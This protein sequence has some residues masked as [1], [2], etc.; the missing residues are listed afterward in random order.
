MHRFF[1]G[2]GRS[3]EQSSGGAD[4]PVDALAGRLS[5]VS[6]FDSLLSLTEQCGR[7]IQEAM[8]RLQGA[9]QPLVERLKRFQ[10]EVP[11]SCEPLAQLQRQLGACGKQLGGGGSSL[12]A[13]ARLSSEARERSGEVHR[14]FESRGK[15]LAKKQQCSQEV[16][17]IHKRFGPAFS[18]ESKASRLKAKHEAEEEFRVRDEEAVQKVA[19][20]LDHRWAFLQPILAELC[21]WHA[22]VFAGAEELTVGLAELATRLSSPPAAGA[23]PTLEPTVSTSTAPA[24]GCG[25]GDGGT[26]APTPLAVCEPEA[27]A[28]SAL[29]AA[30]AA[31]PAAA[32]DLRVGERVEVWS[33]GQEAWL[34]GVVEQIFAVEAVEDGFRVPAGVVKVS[35]ATGVK[36]VRPEAIATTLRRLDAPDS[37][38]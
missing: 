37:T 20:V 27:A 29:A 38:G 30:A 4:D 36:F 26:A 17:A 35:M 16:E 13:L 34:E 23:V 31:Q 6:D 19:E 32:A 10:S 1:E 14:L 12:Q 5:E 22:A 21:R 15:A 11:C 33:T 2:R 28:K 3:K 9:T 7:D 25:S 8:L 24:P 18:L